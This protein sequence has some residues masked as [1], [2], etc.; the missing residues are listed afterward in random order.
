MGKLDPAAVATVNFN[1]LQRCAL[2][3]LFFEAY[4]QGL[5]PVYWLTI[6]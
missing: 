2:N 3:I 1:K 4:T 5:I 6:L